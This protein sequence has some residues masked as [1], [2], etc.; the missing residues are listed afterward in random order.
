MDCVLHASA[1]MTKDEIIRFLI[2][3]SPLALSV[4]S[5]AGDVLSS[6][7]DGLLQLYRIPLLIVSD[8]YTFLSGNLIVMPLD[9][10]AEVKQRTPLQ[11]AG[12]VRAV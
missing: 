11:A 8:Y 5:P 6:K 9:V 12:H 4:A 1:R 3:H 10:S 2:P 7:V